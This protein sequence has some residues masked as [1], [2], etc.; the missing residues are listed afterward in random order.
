MTRIR[1]IWLIRNGLDFM[2]ILQSMLHL[3]HRMKAFL[4]VTPDRL[5]HNRCQFMRKIGIKLENRGRVHRNMLIHHRKDILAIKGCA[6]TEHFV[7]Q[8]AN[9]IN[10]RGRIATLTLQLF[11]R[12]IIR[13]AHCT[14]QTAPRD[15]ASP[16]Q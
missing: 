3:L 10:I 6:P 16:L 14:S 7:E 8:N 1:S 2:Q 5:H 15:P 9:R 12:H 13:S 4:R 11:G